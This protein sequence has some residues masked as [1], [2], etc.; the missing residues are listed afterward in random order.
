MKEVLKSCPVCDTEPSWKRILKAE[1]YEKNGWQIEL[2]PDAEC[3]VCEKINDEHSYIYDTKKEAREAWPKT[4][5]STAMKRRL[6]L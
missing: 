1:G 2:N 3:D 5:V 4:L 6:G